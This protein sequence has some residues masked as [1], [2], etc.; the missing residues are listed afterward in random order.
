MLLPLPPR[1]RRHAPRYK[2]GERPRGRKGKTVRPNETFHF[3]T[4]LSSTIPSILS[5]HFCTAFHRFIAQVAQAGEAGRDDEALVSIGT[6][7]MRGRMSRRS[8]G[9]W[10]RRTCNG[11]WRCDILDLE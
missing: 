7:R 6:D 4:K 1:R 2:G 9:G 11:K 3:A 5:A 10:M 8:F